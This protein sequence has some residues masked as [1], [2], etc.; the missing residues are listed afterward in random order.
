MLTWVVA[1]VLATLAALRL[2]G[3]GAGDAPPIKVEGG[4]SVATDRAGVGTEG[5]ERRVPIGGC[6]CMWRG[7]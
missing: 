3:G 7:R 1:A 4:S 6:T 5:E 2:F